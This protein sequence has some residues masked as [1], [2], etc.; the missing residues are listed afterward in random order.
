MRYKYYIILQQTHW[1]P[2]LS[3]L[4][5]LKSRHVTHVLHDIRHMQ[6]CEISTLQLDLWRTC[7]VDIVSSCSSEPAA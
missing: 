5:S 6:Y 3:L 4:T 7:T 1:A 2:D